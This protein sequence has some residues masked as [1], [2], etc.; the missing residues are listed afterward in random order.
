MLDC[1][2]QAGQIGLC[3][4]LD[5]H[6]DVLA[7]PWGKKV[8]TFS[9]AKKSNNIVNPASDAISGR[10]LS[11][12]TSGIVPQRPF[13]AGCVFPVVERLL[14]RRAS[15]DTPTSDHACEFVAPEAIEAA[16]N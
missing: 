2:F 1:L 9:R 6:S 12:M 7:R 8:P 16:D 14:E 11:R 10:K 13:D 3:Q 5:K 4:H 15:F